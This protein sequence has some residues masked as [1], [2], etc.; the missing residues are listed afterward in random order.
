MQ[1]KPKNLPALL[2]VNSLF[3]EK[4]KTPCQIAERFNKIR[5]IWFLN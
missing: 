3:P 2:K 5:I 1:S 4:K